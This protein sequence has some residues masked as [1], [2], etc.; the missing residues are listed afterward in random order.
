MEH[1]ERSTLIHEGPRPVVALQPT[2]SVLPWDC[3]AVAALV[4]VGKL[5]FFAN[6]KARMQLAV[7]NVDVFGRVVAEMELLTKMQSLD[8]SDRALA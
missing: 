2:V 3:I 8:C 5:N 4:K 1:W 6:G 7:A